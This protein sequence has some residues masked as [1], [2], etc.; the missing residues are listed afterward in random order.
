MLGFIGFP[1]AAMPQT[2]RKVVIPALHEG[3]AD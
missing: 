1:R 2:V 3:I